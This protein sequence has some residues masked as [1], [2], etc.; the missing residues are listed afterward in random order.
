M[1]NRVIIAGNMVRDPETSH[2][3]SGATLGR[4]TVAVN[5]KF[6]VQGEQREEVSF[7]D[8]TVFNA[9]ADIVARHGYKG[10]KILLEGRLKQDRWED[11][12]TG[13]KR[14]KVYI[15]ADHVRFLSYKDDGDGARSEEPEPQ[16]HGA[17][18]GS[19]EPPV[20]PAPHEDD[21]PF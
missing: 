20:P 13:E 8:V 3:P 14:S 12:A 15:I 7:F 16:N 9:V 17:A 10:Q 4:F 19:G 1:F 21:I 5:R 6:K 11:R 18:Q 2:L